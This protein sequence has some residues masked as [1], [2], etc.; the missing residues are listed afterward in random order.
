[1]TWAAT[2]ATVRLRAVVT[3]L[4]GA[5]LTVVMPSL[6]STGAESPGAVTLAVVTLAFT[7]LARR[8]GGA[9]PLVVHVRACLP[10]T[11]DDAPPVLAARVTDPVH[12][13]LRPRAP[14][15]A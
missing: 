3:A 4:V 8:G 6:L 10:Q 2:D 12:H 7:A 5:A 15:L 13:P 9:L 1:M 14:G 11:G